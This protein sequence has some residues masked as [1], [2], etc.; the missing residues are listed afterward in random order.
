LLREGGIKLDDLGHMTSPS[1]EKTKKELGVL[2]SSFPTL[3]RHQPRVSA[4]ENSLSIQ[5]LRFNVLLTP[6]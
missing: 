4:I 3:C 6:S 2:Y 5:M 1:M